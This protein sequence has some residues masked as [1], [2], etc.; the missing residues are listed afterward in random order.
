MPETSDKL[1]LFTGFFTVTR[2]MPSGQVG[3]YLPKKRD[4]FSAVDLTLSKFC[5]IRRTISNLP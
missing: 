5:H 4:C 2:L 3:M 1:F